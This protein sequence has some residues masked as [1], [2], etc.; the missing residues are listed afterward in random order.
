LPKRGTKGLEGDLPLDEK[1]NEMLWIL[2]LALL[3]I[4][5]AGGIAIS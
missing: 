5:I 4:A 1:E 2:A 3:I